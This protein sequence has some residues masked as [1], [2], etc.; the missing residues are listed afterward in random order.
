MNLTDKII[1]SQLELTKS[2]ADGVGI[3]SSRAFQDR[4]GRLMH[5]TRRRDV[6]VHDELVNEL[7]GAL[8]VPRDELRGGMMLYLHGGGYVAGSLEYAKGFAAVLSAE[9]GIKVFA[10]EYRLAPE[11]PYPA[12]L[13]DAEEAYRR[14]LDTGIPPEKIVLAGESAGGGLCYALCQRIRER[15]LPAPAGIIA[16]SPW[17]DLTL[18]GDSYRH[19]K[20]ADPS[21]TEDRLEFYANCYVGVEK[22]SG[23][24]SA[25]RSKRG[26]SVQIHSAE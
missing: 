4:I 13:D 24:S 1:R 12:A 21:I 8:I 14:V 17:V 2:I 11:N 20:E 5:F 16:V 23:K 25:K 3:D 19:N 10:A 9:C 15:G 22:Y 7:G 26:Q 18:S 6:V